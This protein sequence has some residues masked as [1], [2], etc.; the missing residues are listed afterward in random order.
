MNVYSNLYFYITKKWN[1]NKLVYN[2]NNKY[3]TL[4]LC[5]IYILL[6][7]FQFLINVIS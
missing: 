1:T 7:F 3:F 6:Y 5:M 4:I 2:Y